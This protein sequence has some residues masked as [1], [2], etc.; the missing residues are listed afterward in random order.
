MQKDAQF[1]QG[2]NEAS[3]P[4][5]KAVSMMTPPRVSDIQLYPVV[6]MEREKTQYVNSSHGS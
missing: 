6:I 5:N 3:S 1:V 2:C 4:E